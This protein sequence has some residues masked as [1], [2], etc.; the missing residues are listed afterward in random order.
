MKLWNFHGC[1][2]RR[3]SEENGF[4]DEERRPEKLRGCFKC[5]I[6]DI[7]R[8]PAPSAQ[9]RVLPLV[10]KSPVQSGFSAKFSAQPQLGGCLLFRFTGNRQPDRKK[11]VFFGPNLFI[12]RSVV[13]HKNVVKNLKICK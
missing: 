3:R 5:V 12:L 4:V 6:D 10:F 11:P 8:L 1:R 2:R 13:T 9:L 7:G